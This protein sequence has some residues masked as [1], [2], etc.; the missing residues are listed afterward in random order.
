MIR[1]N[2]YEMVPSQHS[3]GW[4]LRVDHE[5]EEKKTGKVVTVQKDLGYDMPIEYCIR[6][7]IHEEIRKNG[8]FKT[9]A[10]FLEGYK[11]LSEDLTK[12][13]EKINVKR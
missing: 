5:R 6:K 13:M 3:L 2:Q 8:D 12:K 9:P 11:K 7:I 4:D 10:Q 1:I